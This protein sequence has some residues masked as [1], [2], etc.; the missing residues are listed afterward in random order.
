VGS[1]CWVCEGW[2]QV[3]FCFEP[4]VS[5]DTKEHDPLKGIKLHLEID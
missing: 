5:D 2:T 3:K 1:N 4:G